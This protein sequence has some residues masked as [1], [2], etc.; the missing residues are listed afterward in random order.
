MNTR[1]FIRY[2]A[3]AEGISFLL[4]LGIAMP[5]KYYFSMPMAVRHIGMIHG[6][7]FFVL[8]YALYLAWKELK[9]SLSFCLWGFLLSLIP[10]GAFYWEYLIKKKY[11]EV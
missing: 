10:F 3:L 9:W 2:T 4:L 11:P 5:L 6:I 7:L 8:I 1:T